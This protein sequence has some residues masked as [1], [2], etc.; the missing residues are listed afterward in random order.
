MSVDESYNFRRVSDLITTS[1]VVGAERLANLRAEGY[2]AVINLLPDSS[3]H[4]VPNEAAILEAQGVD[5]VSI[6]VDFGAPTGDDFQAF[7]EA[8]DARAGQKIHVHCAANFRVSAFYSL[9]ASR[10]GEWSTE[11]ADDFMH[12]VWNP[13]AYPGWVALIAAERSRT[14]T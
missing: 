7:V 4:A 12:T 1:G 9:Y 8:M 10:T 13:A 14:G 2:D 3:E 6:P 5:Y 11:D